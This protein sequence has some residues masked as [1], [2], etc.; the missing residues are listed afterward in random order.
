MSLLQ[1]FVLETWRDYFL[2]VFHTNVKHTLITLSIGI[3]SSTRFSL[4]ECSIQLSVCPWFTSLVLGKIESGISE[5]GSFGKSF[6]LVGKE[7]KNW[8]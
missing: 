8:L 7:S 4:R 1:C 6:I 2:L 3:F 5:K